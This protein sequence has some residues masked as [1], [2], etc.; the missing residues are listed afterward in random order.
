MTRFTCILV[1]D[2]TLLIGCGDQLRDCGHEI[3]AVVSRNP[4]IRDWASHEGLPTFDDANAL[5]DGPRADGADWLL[6][7]AN[8]SVIPDDVRALARRGAVNFH[9]GP[10]P[11][12]AG[13]NTPV[14]ALMAGETKHGVTWHMMEGGVDTGD[15]LVQREIAIEPGETAHSLNSKCYAAG[16]DSFGAVLDELETGQPHRRPQDLTQRGYFGA[17]HR[18]PAGGRLDFARPSDDLAR[19]VRALD[20]GGYWNP[21]ARPRF[22]AGGRAFFVGTAEAIARTDEAAPGRVLDS[23]GGRLVIAT[24]DGAIALSSLTDAAGRPVHPQD[25]AKAGQVLPCP[26]P[27]DADRLRALAAELAG[28]QDRWR[29][30]LAGM[31]PVNVPLAGEAAHT[32]NW[33]ETTLHLPRGSDRD[34]RI[35][36]LALWALQGAGQVAADVAMAH[37]ALSE[38][39]AASPDQLTPWVPLRADTTGC[40]TFGELRA[41]IAAGLAETGGTQGFALDLPSRDPALDPAQIPGVAISEGGRPFAG[42][43]IHAFLHSD[44]TCNL[45]L[46]RARLSDAAIELLV[47]RLETMV[48]R[49]ETGGDTDSLA[50]DTLN[51]LPDAERAMLLDAGAGPEAAY[52]A[53]L[54]VPRDFERQ[55]AETPEAVALVFEDRALT[56]DDLNAQANAVASRL[57][58]AGVGPGVAVGLCLRR[59]L[60]LVIG[61]L[62]IMKAGGAYVPLD[63]E[64]PTERLAHVLADS[65]ATVVLAHRQ[66]EALLSPVSTDRVVRLEDALARKPA[67]SGNVDGGAGPDDPAYVIYTSGSTGTPKGVAVAH[68]NL[69]NFFRGMDDLVDREAGSVWLAVTSIAFDISVLELFYTL[70]R[71]FKVVLA[72]GE[73][74]AAVGGTS[75][76]VSDRPMEFSLYYWGNDDGPGPKKYELLLEGAKFADANGFA[77]IW[78]PERHFH[79]FGGPY[80]NPAVSGAAVAAVTGNISVRA[81]SCVAPLHHP[82]RIA[83]DWAV[84]DNLTS[85][86]AGLALASGWHPDDFVLRPENTPPRNKPALFDT[87][88]KVR[89]LW[90]GEAVGFPT[91]TGEMREVRTLP[92]PVSE[93]LECWVTTAGNPETWRDAGRHGA[94][95]LTHLLG[96]T[97]E[98]VAEKIKIYHGALREA[99]H[100][101]DDFKV[102]VMLHTFIAPTRDAARE[103]ARGPMKDYLRSAAGLIKQYAWAFPAFKKPQGV[104]SPFELDLGALDET[105]MEAILDFAFERYFEDAGL[106]GTVAD[107]VA[108]A[109]QLKRIG[110]DEIACL[111]D[112]GIAP[113]TVLDGLRPL[114]EVMRTANTP[115]QPA[116]DDH[117]IAA[118]ILRHGVTHMQCTP[119]MARLLAMN[120]AARGALWHVKQLLLGGEALPGDLV[121]DLRGATS[122]QI[123]NMYGP[124]ETTIW[125]SAAR[126]DGAVGHTAPLGRAIA[127]TGLYVLGPEGALAPT[128]VP[129]ELFIGGE[130]V[131]PGYWKRDDLTAE[132]FVA[133]PFAT[134]GDAARLYR[135][136]D[137]VRW[138][139]D[140]RLDFLGRADDQVKV[141]GQRIE[142]GEIESCMKR[143]AG[144]QEAVVVARDRAGGDT[145]LAGYYTGA[146]P[147][148]AA[149][150]RAHLQSCL[151]EA[152]IPADLVALDR[153]PL[154]PNRKIDRAALPD[155]AAR[156]TDAPPPRAAEG[157]SDMERTLAGIWASVLGV[158]DIAPDD[159]FFD[160]GGH[161]LLAVQAHR[162]IRARTGHS[163]LSI[164]DIF[165]F[166]VLKDLA[167]HIEGHAEPAPPEPVTAGPARDTTI[168]KRRAMR[169]GRRGGRGT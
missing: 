88:Q 69:A 133:D 40:A 76:P 54:T 152:M 68:R 35:A 127:N 131:T 64:Y 18:P 81:G 38:R 9:D 162:D 67:A 77:A 48:T 25:I 5:R 45:H 13:L 29:D 144:V 50:L 66:T 20:F 124:T 138:S 82:A 141:R 46:D 32:P 21:V 168:S 140:G 92:R 23:A 107:G 169:A 101:P 30:R 110:V 94:H 49:A 149:R 33:A 102:T 96:Q 56:F 6:S 62:A 14:W 153:M 128:G 55:A 113:E 95:V 165:R 119:S 147:S 19:T 58:A 163:T 106:F 99:G 161:S 79:A 26:S 11:G 61:A 156:D 17:R 89:A 121:D 2:E 120:D 111:I 42:P 132:R 142:L 136:G 74:P 115:T 150:L 125:S 60:D 73:I 70:A 28:H 86:R 143:F 164:T 166:P 129:G 100:D 53:A 10:L 72:G 159:N 85:G 93:T 16:L 158:R 117:S 126:V 122:A 134:R 157:G 130:G 139:P 34:A 75:V 105:E 7:I 114:A 116:E 87:M 15:I 148:A 36:L 8:L 145:R 90:R 52:D 41:A 167:R 123:L 135:T 83:E 1:G 51:A 109:E 137:L 71:G 31:T 65:R 47:A 108:R 146:D 112:Y 4:A 63:P 59:S 39:A 27:D 12:Y 118:Q 154:T 80:P 160:L 84:I 104:E 57:R 97:I 44:G 43:A 3:L 155:P 78:T 22:T 91:E 37:A 103:T 24:Q 151:P 98:E